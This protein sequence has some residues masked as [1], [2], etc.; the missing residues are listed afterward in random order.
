MHKKT[1]QQTHKAQKPS[2]FLGH[3]GIKA[4]SKDRTI[5]CT[6][7]VVIYILHIMMGGKLI[8]YH[9]EFTTR[10]ADLVATKILQNSMLST[11][12]NAK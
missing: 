5:T 3:E 11:T 8:M 7:V 1:Q 10:T 9:G 12:D 2:F 6:Y 4:I